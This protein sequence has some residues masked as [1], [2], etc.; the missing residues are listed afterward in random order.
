MPRIGV[1]IVAGGSGVRMGSPIPK[2]FLPLQ[3]KPLLVRTVERLLS[4]LPAARMVI[5]LPKDEIGRWTGIMT[6]YGLQGTH[7]LC[8]GGSTRFESVKNA[9]STI[10]PCDIIAV[11]DG[12]RP[13]VSA[14]LVQRVIDTASLHGTAIPCIAPD[15]SFRQLTPDG[16]S[17]PIDRSMLRA[18]QTPQAFSA[19]L[20]HHAYQTPYDPRFTDDASVVEYSE[21][22]PV[23]LCEGDPA[24]IKITTP[25]HMALAEALLNSEH[26]NKI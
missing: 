26:G 23:T 22:W 19:E 1:I 8:N 3:G 9:L 16:G 12:V 14:G 4:I 17:A 10:G 15:D 7:T 6:E 13:F 24:N 21:G 25:F 2:Q 18:V 5:A 20:L 11:H